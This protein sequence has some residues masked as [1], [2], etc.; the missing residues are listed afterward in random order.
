MNHSQS[1]SKN[2]DKSDTLLRVNDITSCKLLTNYS[3]LKMNLK[4]EKTY[5]IIRDISEFGMN[6]YFL[7]GII[8]CVLAV[9]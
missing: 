9:E 6:S 5:N 3:L 4:K 8:D 2:I 7:I 1:I